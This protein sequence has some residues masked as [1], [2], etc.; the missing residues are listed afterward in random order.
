VEDIVSTYTGYYGSNWGTAAGLS[1]SGHQSLNSI[2]SRSSSKTNSQ[3][4]SSNNASTGDIPS[5][6]T[7]RQQQRERASELPVT[8]F[9]HYPLGSYGC[10]SESQL[11]GNHRANQSSSHQSLNSV[12]GATTV[13]KSQRGRQAH[14][15]QAQQQ[16]QQQHNNN[17]ASHDNYS[18]HGSSGGSSR[19]VLSLHPAVQE[20][21]EDLRR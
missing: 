7:E 15:Q 1:S 19:L 12:D 10:L 17:G 18:S 4:Q 2:S 5:S 13:G 16:Q 8:I 6:K 14:P 9:D 11:H 3:L 20:I 21:L